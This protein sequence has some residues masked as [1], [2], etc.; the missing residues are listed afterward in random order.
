V[1]KSELIFIN[2]TNATPASRSSVYFA[3]FLYSEDLEL[4][5]LEK[6]KAL[7]IRMSGGDGGLFL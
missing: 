2:I 7:M 3:W 6:G 5:A 1:P 4:A